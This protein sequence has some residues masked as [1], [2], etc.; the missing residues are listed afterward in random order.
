M[1]AE[2]PD[3]GRVEG[4]VL[5]AYLCAVLRSPLP[6]LVALMLASCKASSRVDVTAFMPDL[7]GHVT[8]APGVVLIALPYDR[9]SLLAAL[10][11]KAP[12]PRPSTA[13]LD[14]LHA[15]VQAPFAAFAALS[16][17]VTSLQDSAARLKSGLDSLPRESPR[18]RA[19]YGAFLEVTAARSAAEG[20]QAV[21]RRTLNRAREAAR[22]RIDSARAALRAWEDSAYADYE[23]LTG[24]LLRRSAVQ[25]VTDT[26]DGNGAATLQLPRGRDGRW[27]IYARTWDAS[28]PNAEWYWNIPVAGDS[29]RLGPENAVRRGRY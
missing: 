7:Q 14:S 3:G 24:E 15:R 17:S 28:D 1:Q 2:R 27:W 25:G 26:T 12:S 8:P 29:V 10:D 22:P 11:A 4:D 20:R 6:I 18:Y 21:A 16:D 5:L 9:D 19:G 23:K 13:L